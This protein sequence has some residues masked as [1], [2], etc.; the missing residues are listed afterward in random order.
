M[1]ASSSSPG[2]LTILSCYATCSANSI[3][4]HVFLSGESEL[5]FHSAKQLHFLKTGT[6]T[7][8]NSCNVILFWKVSLSQKNF[9]LGRNIQPELV[10]TYG[11]MQAEHA[12]CFVGVRSTVTPCN[13]SPEMRAVFVSVWIPARPCWECG[14][15]SGYG[16]SV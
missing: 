1:E 15:I 8:K 5:F 14:N 9:C 10:C 2:N 6:T 16:N 4:P 3:F 13:S 7:T 11:R 12:S